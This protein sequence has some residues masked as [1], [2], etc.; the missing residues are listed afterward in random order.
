MH[1]VEQNQGDVLVLSIKGK[2]V[3]TPETD[4]LHARIKTIMDNN[5]KKVV[6]DLKHVNW[7]ASVGIGAL[8]RCY[9]T[10]HNAGGDL[11][12]TGLNEKVQNL[13]SITKLSGIIHIYNTVADAV[14]SYENAQ[15]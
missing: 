14:K 7:I 5:A 10:V 15:T 2:L 9:T 1:F 11:K 3:D 13:F 6:I 4:K 8:L 12:L